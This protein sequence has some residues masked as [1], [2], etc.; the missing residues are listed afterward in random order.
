MKKINTFL[1]NRLRFIQHNFNGTGFTLMELIVVMAIIFMISGFVTI[2]LLNQQRT[3]SLSSSADILIADINSQKTKA[4]S[5]TTDGL[6]NAENY[7][8]Y[9]LEDRYILFKGESFQETDPANFTIMLDE[10]IKFSTINFAGNSIVFSVQ[11]GEIMGFLEGNNS[12]VIQDLSGG[13]SKTITIN[14]Y[15]VVINAN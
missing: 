5:G 8:I 15:G 7:G 11:T 4:M 12:I 1:K 2:G 13:E 9:F 6:A 3:T 10:D 14:R